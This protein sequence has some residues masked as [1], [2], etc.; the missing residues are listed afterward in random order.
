LDGFVLKDAGRITCPFMACIAHSAQ[1]NVGGAERQMPIAAY[2]R[3]VGAALL[4]LLWIGNF[5]L[6]RPPLAQGAAA[7]PPVI[8]IHSDRKWPEP[9]IFDTT[10]VATAAAA[11]SP[12]DK[13]PPAPPTA[14]EIPTNRSGT[15]AARDALALMNSRHLASV[16]QKKRQKTTKYAARGTRK[17]QRPQIVFAARQGH[18][19]WL[20]FSYW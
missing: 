2:F 18:Y 20:G 9:V 5:Y 15:S 11:P 12:W 17:Y 13:N 16:E 19:A 14:R 1:G 4:A 10:K 8:R 3:N 7:Y 6:P